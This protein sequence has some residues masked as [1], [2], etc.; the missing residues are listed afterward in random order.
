MGVEA[1]II[2]APRHFECFIFQGKATRIDGATAEIVKHL[3]FSLPKGLGPQNLI[4][5]ELRNKRGSDL[6]LRTTVVR[7]VLFF[8]VKRQ[9]PMELQL[10]T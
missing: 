9:E 1:I 8:R 2:S 6:H 4:R 7:M 3:E 10:K 5:S